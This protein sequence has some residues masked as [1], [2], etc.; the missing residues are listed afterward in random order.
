M[1][2]E[3]RERIL[4]A[5]NSAGIVNTTTLERYLDRYGHTIDWPEDRER[6]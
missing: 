6:N 2:H 5:L 1:K 3:I 4:D